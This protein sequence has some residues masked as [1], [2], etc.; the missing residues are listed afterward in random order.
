KIAALL[1]VRGHKGGIDAA[2][3]RQRHV[4][5]HKEEGFV[6]A[7]IDLRNFHRASDGESG[8]VLHVSRSALRRGEKIAAVQQPVAEEVVH[9]AVQ[10]VAARA[11]RGDHYSAARVA[12][13]GRKRRS[14]NLELL[15]RIRARRQRV[16][17]I[18]GVG[19]WESVYQNFVGRAPPARKA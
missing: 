10:A 3:R 8:V 15:D 17:F 14:Q 18:R 5:I 12:V 7:V 4:E 13:L 11:R 2:L 16:S 1:Q 9:A 19:G 6:P